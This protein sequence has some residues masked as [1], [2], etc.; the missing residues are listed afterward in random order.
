MGTRA[1]VLLEFGSEI[2]RPKLKHDVK[3][4]KQLMLIPLVFSGPRRRG[5]Q[6]LLP[7]SAWCLPVTLKS[8]KKYSLFLANIFLTTDARRHSYLCQYKTS[9]KHQNSFHLTYIRCQENV[10]VDHQVGFKTLFKCTLV[11]SGQLRYDHH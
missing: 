3:S 11:A 4:V 7:L 10:H 2:S 8:M 9:R 6:L 1:S 5:R